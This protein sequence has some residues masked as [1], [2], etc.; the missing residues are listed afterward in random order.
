MRCVGCWAIHTASFVYLLLSGPEPANAQLQQSHFLWLPPSAGEV[1]SRAVD[2]NVLKVA[3]P[4]GPFMP[5]ALVD[6][7]F[8][9]GTKLYPFINYSDGS[10]TKHGGKQFHPISTGPAW[11]PPAQQNKMGS[12]LPFLMMPIIEEDPV[13]GL[14][15]KA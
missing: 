8:P 14:V 1:L 7:Y 2:T 11:L 4:R 3:T 5:Q 10:I 12:L 6:I 15:G 9:N 13:T